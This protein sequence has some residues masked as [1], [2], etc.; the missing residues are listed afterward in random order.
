MQPRDVLSQEVKTS[1]NQLQSPAASS[2]FEIKNRNKLTIFCTFVSA[3]CTPPLPPLSSS[4]LVPP[5]SAA[6]LAAL[7]FFSP[8][9]HPW[10][11]LP[12]TSPTELQIGLHTMPQILIHRHNA[13][14]SHTPCFPLQLSPHPFCPPHRV[15]SFPPSFRHSARSFSFLSPLPSLGCSGSWVD[16]AAA[17]RRSIFHLIPAHWAARAEKSQ[18]S[19][20][21]CRAKT[22]VASAIIQTGATP[23]AASATLTLTNGQKN[24]WFVHS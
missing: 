23:T 24:R 7:T 8:G 20:S 16:R 18:S 2:E 5:H 17:D 21:H 13:P 3:F 4:L 19:Q 12:T 1:I 15:L 22:K 14:T 10:L 9:P 11:G 6:R